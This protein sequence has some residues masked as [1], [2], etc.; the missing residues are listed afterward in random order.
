MLKL[1]VAL[2]LSESKKLTIKSEFGLFVLTILN[3]RYRVY[4][5]F[6]AMFMQLIK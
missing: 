4:I 3:F 5:W 6:V 1:L 2:K